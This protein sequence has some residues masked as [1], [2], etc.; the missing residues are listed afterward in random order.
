MIELVRVRR[1]G[2][3]TWHILD[4]ENDV[5]VRG[6]DLTE[7]EMKELSKKFKEAGF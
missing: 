3:D 4:M 2:Y 5:A 7:D 6:I 1:L